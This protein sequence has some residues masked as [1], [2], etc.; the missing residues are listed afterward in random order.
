MGKL[1]GVIIAD[2][3]QH[4]RSPVN[5]PAR[6]RVANGRS[7]PVQLMDISAAGASLYYSTP[8]AVG[9]PVRLKF[10]LP[11][12]L[13]DVPLRLIGRV[14]KYHLRGESHLLRIAFTDPPHHAIQAISEFARQKLDASK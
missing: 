4:P 6:M 13:D 9:T 5:R 1:N 3:R 2:R 11:T 7:S 10:H 12:C 14:K 8:L